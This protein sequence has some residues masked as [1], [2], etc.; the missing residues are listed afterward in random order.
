MDGFFGYNKILIAVEDIPKTIFRC[1]GSI[2]AFEWMVMPFGLK[3]A[4][5]TYQRAMDAIFH[6]ML[7]HHVEVYIDLWLNLKDPVRM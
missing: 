2:G 7:G 6:D 1:L 4:G 3:N 5:T